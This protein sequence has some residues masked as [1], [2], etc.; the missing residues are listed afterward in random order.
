MTP[1][2]APA[3]TFVHEDREF[4]MLLRIAAD[5]AR[6]PPGLVEK[7]YWVTHTLWSLQQ[8]GFSLWLKGGTS[9]SKGF[10]LIQRFSEDL[11]LRIEPGTVTRVPTIANWRSDGKAATQ[12]RTAYFDAL[13]TE[14]EVPGASIAE[15]RSRRDAGQRGAEFHVVYPGLFVTELGPGM[16]PYVLLEVGSARVT[17]FVERDMS[18]FVHDELGRVGQVAAFIDNRPR[19]LRCVHPYVTLLE[20][21]DALQRRVPR[22]ST[23]PATFIRHYEDAVRIV[24]AEPALPPLRDIAGVRGLAEQML[25]E[26]QIAAMPAQEHVAFG[27]PPGERRGAVLRAHA[28]IGHM[29]WGGRVGLDDACAALREWIAT[30][31]AT[32]P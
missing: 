11:D 27:L 29:F 9:L 19:G 3:R 18:S 31:L 32:A 5:R 17:P 6:I 1:A 14:I 13:G 8:T 28:D 20:K 4:P 12:A 15:D 25:A 23:A 26:R 2:S 21:L 10:G 16:R 30:R 22:E 24:R 7:D